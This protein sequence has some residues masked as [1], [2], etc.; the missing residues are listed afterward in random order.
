MG[1]ILKT[2]GTTVKVSPKNGKD[3]TLEEMQEIVGGYIEI[4]PCVDSTKILVINEE[5]KLENLPINVEATRIADISIWDCIVG[6]ALL[7]ES[8]EVK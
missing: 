6:D 1:Q 4:V 8:D 7:C 5:G 3:Y 2:D